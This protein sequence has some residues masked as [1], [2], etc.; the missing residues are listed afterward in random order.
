MKKL[1]KFNSRDEFIDHVADNALFEIGE[2][3]EGEVYLTY[4]NNVIKN[5]LDS[6][7]PKKYIVY[8]DLIMDDELKLDSFIFPKELYLLKGIIVGYKE[9]YFANNIFDNPLLPNE[10]DIDKLVVAR[11]KFIEDTKAMTDA[12]YRLYELP[13]NLLFDNNRLV[14]IDTLD[15]I[16]NDDIT[17]DENIKIVDYAILQALLGRYSFIDCRKTFDS[18]IEKVY[19]YR[20]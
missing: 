7:N 14:A 6:I 13:G 16:K 17:L 10:I 1:V 2:G 20:K 9:N 18:E 19:E 11:K 8:N 12:G 5:M 4:D 15:Y 3:S